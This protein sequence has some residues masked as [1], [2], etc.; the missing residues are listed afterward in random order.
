MQEKEINALAQYIL[1]YSGDYSELEEVLISLDFFDEVY[2]FLSEEN[3]IA[4]ITKSQEHN[5]MGWLLPQLFYFADA[6]TISEVVFSMILSFKMKD[7]RRNILIALAHC[8]ISFYQL[9]FICREKICIE[10]FATLLASYLVCN[11]F[12]TIDLSKLL[13]ENVALLGGIAWDK[14]LENNNLDSNKRNILL[15][16]LKYANNDE[17]DD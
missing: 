12:S 2:G 8:N 4:L 11:C 1:S 15:S 14:V 7:V 9:E 10:A 6:N 13:S 16:Y 17:H 5:D 3:A